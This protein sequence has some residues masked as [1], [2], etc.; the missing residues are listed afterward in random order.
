MWSQEVS[1]Y[2]LWR[3]GAAP[4]A[5]LSNLW[6]FLRVSLHYLVQT[7]VSHI[8]VIVQLSSLEQKT[9][10]KAQDEGSALSVN[11]SLIIFKFKPHTHYQYNII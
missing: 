8:Q 3:E 5:V 4:R 7:S 6:N 9:T 11:S 10:F 1:L 2:L